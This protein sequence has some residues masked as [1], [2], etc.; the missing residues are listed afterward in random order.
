MKETKIKE[1]VLKELTKEDEL[2]KELIN[3]NQSLMGNAFKRT[4]D[5]TLQNVCEEIK[6]W[7]NSRGLHPSDQEWKMIEED[8]LKELLKKFQGE[9]TKQ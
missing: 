1:N 7:Y 3:D 4:I 8:D 2:L 5:L 9:K 6:K